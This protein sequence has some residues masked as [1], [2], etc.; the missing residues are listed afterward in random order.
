MAFVR[1]LLQKLLL[2]KRANPDD[3]NVL[4]LGYREAAPGPFGHRVSSSNGVMCVFPNTLVALLKQAPWKEL[5]TAIGDDLLLHLLLNYVIVVQV[6]DVKRSFIQVRTYLLSRP[7]L[8]RH[9]VMEVVLVRR[10]R[11]G[12]V[13]GSRSPHSPGPRTTARA[14][15][16]RTRQETT[17]FQSTRCFTLVTFGNEAC[18][19]VRTSLQL[20]PAVATRSLVALRA[21]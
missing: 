15:T 6:D 7:L 18:F 20:P 3:T 19:P 4:A 12:R 9:L 2:R 1:A 16:T 5:H 10:R 11:L 14:A 13:S 21:A 17:Q 8:S